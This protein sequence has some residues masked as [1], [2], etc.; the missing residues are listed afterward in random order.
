MAT[1]PRSPTRETAATVIARLVVM[2][3]PIGIVA[4][5]LGDEVHRRDF[6]VTWSAADIAV[7][8]LQFDAAILFS[9]IL[10]VRA[11]QPQI[12]QGQS[13]SGL[14][15]GKWGSLTREASMRCFWLRLAIFIVLCIGPATLPVGA[16]EPAP[17]RQ[18]GVTEEQLLRQLGPLDLGRI[19]GRISIPDQREGVLEHPAGR[20]W[21]VYHE[22]FLNW[23]GGAVI[24]GVVALLATFYLWRGQIRI[25]GGR[26]ARTILRFSGLERFAHWLAGVC[27]IILGVTGLNFIYGKK[28]LLPLI[29]PEAFTTVTQLGKYAHDF[30]SFPF[31]LG[32]AAMF[33]LWAKENLPKA[34]DL[35]WLKQGGGFIGKVHPP[36][37]KFNAGQKLLFWGVCIA[38]VLIAV[39]GYMLIFPFYFASISGMQL[40]EIVH[41]LGA[42]VFIAAIIAHIYIGSIGMEGGFRAMA[43]GN[44]DLNW[45][46]Q[47]HRLW[48]EQE[49]GRA[50]NVTVVQPEAAE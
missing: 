1:W 30:L 19:Q 43:D 2:A 45:A 47:H 38:T 14:S 18:R 27:F 6:V 31:V 37:G 42:L 44:V 32:V 49:I 50:S 16:Q 26:S 3:V 22:V 7:R 8:R 25:E 39:P 46:K 33:V 23:F 17:N 34:V 5:A 40:A 36:A 15:G 48:V 20:E 10:V 41:S 35:E 24:L 4:T 29:G 13:K 11:R 12:D 9:D 28:L 21:R